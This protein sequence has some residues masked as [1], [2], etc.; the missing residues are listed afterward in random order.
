MSEAAVD[1]RPRVIRGFYVGLW[2]LMMALV[3]AG[4]WP[5]VSAY[6][7]DK[8]RPLTI[9]L[10]ALVFIGWMLLLLTQITLVYRGRTATHRR[11]GRFGMAWGV[12]VLGMGLVATVVAPLA[13]LRAGE[14]TLD[15][16]A[17]FLILP[18]GDM[19]L[20]G[21][22]F[23]VAIRYRRRPEVHKRFILLATVALLFAPAARL[24][25]DRGPAMILL[26][27]LFPL[28]IA[29]GYDVWT[30]RRIHPAY[31]VGTAILLAGF[32]RLFVMQSDAWL[33]V[34]RSLLHALGA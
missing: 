33:G 24:G 4:F 14:W 3:L 28:M 30:R 18:I 15:E 31:V 32:T 34:G 16:A 12:L 20:F 2:F 26:I 11:V 27:W 5:Y 23:A 25:G 7:V 1:A 8:P 21:I 10:H 13:H 6:G 22:L 9:H 19:V 17:A 29:M